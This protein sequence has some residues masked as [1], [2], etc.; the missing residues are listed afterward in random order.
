MIVSSDTTQGLRVNPG[1]ATIF[2][3]YS[4]LF[5]LAASGGDT[6]ELILVPV[7]VP[8]PSTLAMMLAAVACGAGFVRR[9]W[10]PRARS[11][12]RQRV[13]VSSTECHP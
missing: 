2:E 7:A 8:E 5:R 9:R 12:R 6:G 1:G 4:V 13:Y 3:S 10:N 11:A